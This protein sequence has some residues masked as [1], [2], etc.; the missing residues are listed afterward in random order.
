MIPE[1]DNLNDLKRQWYYEFVPFLWNQPGIDIL[2]LGGDVAWRYVH[3][4]FGLEKHAFDRG[5]WFQ[6]HINWYLL[7]HRSKKGWK[8]I[9]W[10]LVLKCHKLDNEYIGNFQ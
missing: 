9:I 2:I 10:E 4:M 3:Q 1:Y 8:C 7:E 5:L 6:Y